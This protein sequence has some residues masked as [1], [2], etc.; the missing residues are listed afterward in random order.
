LVV[1]GETY[2]LCRWTVDLSTLP[3]FYYNS[4]H[5][6][7]GFYTKFDLG[8]ILDSAEVLGASLAR[9]LGFQRPLTSPSRLGAGVL[10]NDDGEECGR[11]TF[12]YIGQ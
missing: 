7:G 2:E 9:S 5:L 6:T 1:P 10:L 11:A 4:Q 3:A 12:E 8:L